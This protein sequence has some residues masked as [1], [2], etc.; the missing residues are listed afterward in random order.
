[1]PL[2]TTQSPVLDVGAVRVQFPAL[3]QRV[4]DDRPLVYLDNA[5]TT[6][7]PQAVLDR[8]TAFYGKEN[9]NIHRGVHWLSQQA[10]DAYEMARQAVA[11]FI[12]AAHPH[13]VIFTRG[14]TESINLVASTYGRRHVRTGDAVVVSSLEHHSNIVPWQMLCE[15]RGAHLEVIPVDERG[16]LDQDAYRALLTDRVRMVA[17]NHISNALGTINPVAEMIE[18]AHR[19]GIPVFVDGAQAA[20]HLKIDVQALDADFYALSAHKVFGPTGVGVLYGKEELLEAMPPYQGGGDMIERVTFEGTT[21]NEL[22][23]KFEAGTP[24]I[25][26]GLGLAAAIDFVEDIGHEAIGTH[27]AALLAY[28]NER[29][30]ALP[31]LQL[32]GTAPE[33]ASVV[34]FLVGDIHPYDAGTILDR[35]GVAVRTGHH[36]A[37]PLMDRLGVPG[38]VRASFALYNTK[39]DVDAL[40]EGIERVRRLFG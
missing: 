24:H 4:Y 19:Y 31:D 18:A 2:P 36:C 26:G 22:P 10:T 17:V 5:A 14:T 33:K 15:E 8:L 29:L 21:F 40:V 6:H 32:V 11:R 12:G 23:H 35:L 9:S 38:T 34:S 39:T 37:Q 1:M 13:E 20:P 3:S 27:E 25:A 16:V 28:A 30:T 7:K